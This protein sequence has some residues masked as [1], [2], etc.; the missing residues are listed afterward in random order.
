[1][2]EFKAVRALKEKKI[3]IT[4]IYLT[5]DA[6]EN[7]DGAG[8]TAVNRKLKKEV[9][10]QFLPCNV[11]WLA[12]DSLR[13]GHGA[14]YQRL[15]NKMFHQLIQDGTMVVYV[16]DLIVKSKAEDDHPQDLEKV[17]SCR[18]D[19]SRVIHAVIKVH[20]VCPYF[21]FSFARSVRRLE[22][23]VVFPYLRSET[24][25]PS[26]ASFA[27][28]SFKSKRST[29]SSIVKLLE[30]VSRNQSASSIKGKGREE[31]VTE[32]G[33]PSELLV[34]ATCVALC[35]YNP[36]HEL[37]DRFDDQYLRMAYQTCHLQ[38]IVQENDISCVNT[39]RMDR[40][41]FH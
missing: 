11:A 3:T 4:S 18:R 34:L 37:R 24:L 40:Q 33:K 13:K 14:T 2:E 9:K 21:R 38:S 27:P 39:L 32:F 1:M 26:N 5:S 31:L 8:R 6:K 7:P 41:A 23:H 16:D 20:V 25:T 36:G 12:P 35:Y 30:K 29:P 10:D 17:C 15:V 22:V 28:V 19:E